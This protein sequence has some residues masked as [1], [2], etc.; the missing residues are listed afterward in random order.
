MYKLEWVVENIVRKLN[1]IQKRKCHHH[2]LT[3][4]QRQWFVYKTTK[5]L[6]QNAKLHHNLNI[7]FSNVYVWEMSLFA[8]LEINLLR[9][10]G[11]IHIF[12][13]ILILEVFCPREK[14]IG[15][16]IQLHQNAE[17]SLNRF[18]S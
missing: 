13:Y 11:V 17:N 4:P 7:K 18:I 2:L 9:I 16:K 15:T 14:E 6:I 1:N 5:G 12:K 3:L 8:C 10:S